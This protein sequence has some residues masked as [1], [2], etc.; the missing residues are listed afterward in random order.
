MS[1]PQSLCSLVFVLVCAVALSHAHAV[2]VDIRWNDVRQ[3][4]DGFGACDAWFSD[5]IMN[6]SRSGEIMDVLFKRDGGIGLSI[7]RQRIDPRW[8]TAEGVY[9]WNQK[10]W[11]GNSW[12]AREALARDCEI[13]WAA[14]WSPPAWMKDNGSNKNGSLKREHYQDYADFLQLVYQKLKEDFGFAYHAISVQNEPGP[15][16]WESCLW[17]DS[18]FIDFIGSHLGPTLDPQVQIMFPEET[19]WNEVNPRMDALLNTPAEQYVDI[20]AGH[21]YHSIPQDNSTAR[22]YD[23]RAVW[24]TE[25]SYNINAEDVTIDNGLT[26]AKNWWHMLTVADVNACHHWWLAE[27]RPNREETNQAALMIAASPDYVLTKR[28]WTL[29]NYSKFVRPGWRRIGATSNP[30]H[31]VFC[32]AFRDTIDGNIAIVLVNKTIGDVT[33]DMSL[34]GFEIQSLT[35]H[36]TSETHDLAEQAPV[37]VTGSSAGVVVPKKSVATYVGQGTQTT[38]T[39]TETRAVN[40]GGGAYTANDG[41]HYAADDWFAGGNTYH[42]ANQIDGTTDDELYQSE[43]FGNF[44][45]EVPMANG[46]YTLALELAEIYETTTGSRVFDIIV[47]GDTVVS[48]LDLVATAGANTAYTVELAVEIVDSSLDIVGKST[49]GNAKLSAWRLSESSVRDSRTPGAAAQA[50]Q[51]GIRLGQRGNIVRLRSFQKDETT[52]LLTDLLGKRVFA[53]Q[54]DAFGTIE[55]Q[56]ISPGMYLVSV[57]SNVRKLTTQI[58]QIP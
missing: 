47:E 6:H 23:G 53:A 27:M 15:K 19:G 14:P 51:R 9:D 34:Q 10:D 40:C 13:I 55:T 38:D 7:L 35:P 32:S 57:S 29:G 5:D 12:M 4:I 52:V 16:T 18:Q 30:T 17:T 41:N 20:V 3:R 33:V 39:T 46:S 25:W 56:P 28:L 2:S 11:V 31:N 49:I 22:N 58:V 45:Y 54:L 48:D 36:I 43:R 50:E 26:W 21:C 37:A 1:K 44:R 24:L 42:T 8:C